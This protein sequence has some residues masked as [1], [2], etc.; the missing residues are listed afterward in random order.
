MEN[1]FLA[2]LSEGGYQ[3]G[4]LACL[5]YPDGVE[6]DVQGHAAQIARTQ[7]LLQRD[8]V[9]IY[10][11]AI[12]APGF[13]VRVDILRKRGQMIELIEVKAKSYDPRTD[14][15]FRDAKG[16]LRSSYL[17]YLQDIA[18]QRYVAGLALP[19]FQFRCFLMLA[20]KSATA[21]VD[22]LNQRFRVR[23]QGRGVAIEVAPGTEGHLGEP[24]LTAVS[25]DSQV[26]EIL[27][28]VVPI[29]GVPTPFAAAAAE[30]A[31]AYR[32]DR[33]WTPTPGTAC[34]NCEFKAAKPP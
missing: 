16:E 24:I 4:A 18:F 2:A 33:R 17:P 25:V 22:G 26:G 28:G 31:N 10:E 20:D 27:S 21:S 12:E 5:M 1:S 6:V 8:E 32:E 19:Q 30:L 14:G 34:G 7:E 29:A 9:T 11:A 23:R 13:F 3:V 15:D